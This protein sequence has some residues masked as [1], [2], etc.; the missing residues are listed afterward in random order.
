[1]VCWHINFRE[2]QVLQATLFWFYLQKHPTEDWTATT[3]TTTSTTS[4]NAIGGASAFTRLLSNKVAAVLLVCCCCCCCCCCC[5]NRVLLVFF[6]GD[7]TILSLFVQKKPH[8][9]GLAT[10]PFRSAA[11]LSVLPSFTEFFFPQDP[12]SS[13]LPSCTGFCIVLFTCDVDRKV[14][15]QD[16]PGFTGFCKW[17]FCKH[18]SF[19]H[20][21]PLLSV[22]RVLLG[23]AKDPFQSSFPPLRSSCWVYRIVT[24]FL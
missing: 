9:I 23:F 17:P 20:K 15:A 11:A 2:S 21:G 12:I 19:P 3:I 7:Q 13:V 18:F 16:L 24:G 6:R 5:R 4:R 1:M 10:H 8:Q 14:L 22:Y